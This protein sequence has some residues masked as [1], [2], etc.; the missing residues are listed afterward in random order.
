[1]LTGAGLD[2]DEYVR[3]SYKFAYADCI[4]VG[5]VACLP[6][7]LDLNN[8]TIQKP[9]RQ[10]YLWMIYNQSFGHSLSLEYDVN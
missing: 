5:P 9:N 10:E 1:M 2:I 8:S 4:E 7:P 3:R 6:E